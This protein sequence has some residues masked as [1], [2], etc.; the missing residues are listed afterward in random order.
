MSKAKDSRAFDFGAATH[1]GLV[2]QENQDFSS[3]FECINGH[4][5]MVCDGMGIHDA[6]AVASGLAV[7]SIRAYLENHYFDMPEDALKAAIEFANSM[8]YKKS[9]EKPEYQGMGT[10]IVMTMIR[11]DK[12]HYAHIGDSRIYIFADGKLH[13]LTRDHS[14]VQNLVDKGVLTMEEARNHP[15]R[16]EVTRALGIGAN[17]EIDFCSS[18]AVPALNDLMLLCTDGLFFMLD[19]TEISDVLRE[20]LTVQEKADK[21]IRRANEK[22]GTDNITVQL[23]CF[24][25][26]TNKKS[27]FASLFYVPKE[28]RPAIKRNDPADVER[29]NEDKTYP[30]KPVLIEEEKQ[31]IEPAGDSDPFVDVPELEVEPVINEPVKDAEP[32]IDAEPVKID[33]PIKIDEPVKEVKSL[34]VEPVQE[35][36]LPKTDTVKEKESVSDEEKASFLD[37]FGFYKNLKEKPEL[38][39]KIKIGVIVLGIVFVAFVFWDLFIKQSATTKIIDT[40]ETV[41]DTVESQTKL[42]GNDKENKTDQAVA[43]EQQPE[44]SDTIWISYSVKKGDFLGTIATKFGV[45]VDFIKKKNKL[46]NDNIREKQKLDIPTKANHTVKSGES[47]AAIAKKYGV[48]KNSVM[49]VNDI[50]DEKNVKAD[51]NL[52]IP[53][54]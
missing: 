6:G 23:I 17:I 43:Q 41:A 28:M 26:V 2:M 16:K 1:T 42:S 5:F 40:Q 15:D 50:K 27:K 14:R 12:V 21:L 53:F 11:F 29:E 54:K 33:E 37:R 39:R 31:I 9:K 51:K 35:K 25:N 36:E 20:P 22:G 24:N 13:R 44:K 32:I 38:F 45:S 3:E 4:V 18:P 19:E 30:E 34:L 52:I 10:T 49:K 48:D 8:V 47:L 46:S 7:E